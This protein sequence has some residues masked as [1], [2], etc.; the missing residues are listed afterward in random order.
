[1]RN[2]LVASPVGVQ[3]LALRKEEV[4]LTAQQA[5]RLL[6]LGRHPVERL[7][8]ADYLTTPTLLAVEQL[9]ERPLISGGVPV[10]RL[11]DPA[12]DDG[13]R[14]G[15]ERSDT[16]MTMLNA[17][18]GWWGGPTQ[19]VR[20]VGWLALAISG[21][22]VGVLRIDDIADV[23]TDQSDYRRVWFEGSLAARIDI[24]VDPRPRILDEQMSAIANQLL[25][26]RVPNPPGAPIVIV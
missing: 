9:C 21:F 22:V 1:M 4:V 18:L 15:H 23:L 14:T 10:L 20:E 24:L 16:D 12:V 3:E 17:A 7:K 26:N 25:G 19:S 5:G 13:R 2:A 6:G 8:R 11:G